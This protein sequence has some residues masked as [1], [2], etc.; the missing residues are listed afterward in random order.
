MDLVLNLMK[1]RVYDG[2]N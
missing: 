2:L 1:V